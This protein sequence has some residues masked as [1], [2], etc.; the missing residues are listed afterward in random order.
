MEISG[1]LT[2]RRDWS[3]RVGPQPA[4]EVKQVLFC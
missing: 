1:I 3:N 2:A 4:D